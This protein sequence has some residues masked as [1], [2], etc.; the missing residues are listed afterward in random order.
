MMTRRKILSRINGEEDIS[1]IKKD[2]KKPVKIYASKIYRM[3]LLKSF[4]SALIAIAV[5]FAVYGT[6]KWN[7]YRN[8]LEEVKYFEL[9]FVVS[10][11]FAIFIFAASFI[12]MM[13]GRIQAII[14]LRDEIARLKKGDLLDAEM[15]VE[16]SD[17]ICQI[18]EGINQMREHVMERMQTEREAIS[19]NHELITAMSHDLRTPLTRQ[20]GYLEILSREKYQSQEELKE[21][22]EKAR[23]NAFLMKDTTDKLFKY[24]LAF[25]KEELLE[26]QI[27]VDGKVLFNAVLKEHIAYI[28]SQG[29]VVSF[30][31]ISEAFKV[32]IDSEEFARIFDNVFHNMKKY[33]DPSVP[34][35]INH[36][37]SEKEFVLMVQNGIKA[38]ISHVES[39]KIGLKIVEKVMKAMGG[40]MEV[41][42]DGQFFII[43]LGFPIAENYDM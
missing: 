2:K 38:D 22:I 33:G 13:R 8:S 1:L 17:E 20:I 18:G 6:W 16:G 15:T 43:Q 40:N 27:E 21:Y 9:A 35:Y 7:L 5:L 19:A 39:T 12:F 34:V 36:I 10:S 25:G 3:M 28:I 41:M 11:L 30:E 31:E 14:R 23:T 29:F 4:F 42:N 32:K 37:F 26:K 24:F